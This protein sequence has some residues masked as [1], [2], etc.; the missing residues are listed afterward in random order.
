[1]DRKK[2]ADMLKSRVLIVDGA[3][4]TMLME[5]DVK[6]KCLDA[7]NIEQPE[8]VKSIHKAYADAGA[9]I[10][11]TNTFG[12]NRLKLAKYGYGNRVIAINQ[13]GVKNAREAAPGCIIA[14]DMGSLGKYIE[15]LSEMTFDEAYELFSEQA[16]GLKEADVI[17][18]ETISDIKVLKAA[19]LAARDNCKLPIIT[20]MTF[21]EGRTP[22]GTDVE[23][24]AAI[25][26]ALDVDAIGANCS[27]GPEGLLKVAEILAKNTGKPICIQPNAG[28]PRIADGKI[29][30]TQTA[31]NFSSYANQF[32]KLGVNLLGGCCGTT[33]AHIRAIAEKLKGKKPAARKIEEKTKLCSRLKTIA[34]E[35]KT[36][37]AGE[38]IN[39]TGKKTFQDELRAGKT[40]YIREQALEQVSQG[41]ALLDVN[42]GVAGLDEKKALP[43][44][45]EII[46]S[47]VDAPLV[48]DSSD[49]VALELA[50]KK[51][52]GKPLINSV[53]G[54]EKSLSSVLPLAKRYGAAVI[55]LTLDDE[56]IPK[57]AEKRV[58]IAEK[59]AGRAEKVGIKKQDIIVDCLVMTIATNPENEKIIIDSL[60]KIKE[61]GYKTILGISNISHGL[62]NRQEINSKFLT[63]SSR[64]GLD[65]AII[66][67]KDNIVQEN[68]DIE[69]F[70]AKKV[71]REEYTNLP[72]EKKL[73][74]AIFYGDKENIIDFIEE[75]LKEMDALR[76]NNILIEAL[77][78]LGDKFN[79]RECFLPQVLASAEAMKKAFSRLKQ[80]LSR[81]GGME[82]GTVLFATVENDVH[83]IGKNIVIALLES[84]NYK[85][86]DLGIDVPK[87][88]IIEAVK[89]YKPDMLG[90]SALMT[91]TAV[92]MEEI[93]KDLRKINIHIP[94]I[95][96]GAVVTKEYSE[97]IKA[98]YSKDALSA[99]KEINKLIQNGNVK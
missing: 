52:D 66:N 31:K 26:E 27:D 67:P 53:N 23:T 17:I 97:Q 98:N 72:I 43:R 90:L 47:L 2:F 21:H 84:H 45:V 89:K 51:S 99:V 83:D 54:S 35:N 14:G 7:L 78:E 44:A 37:I 94:I 34:I 63:K 71:R 76:I 93:I 70:R 87:E 64:A 77:N 22:T 59:I 13:A 3:M 74:N 28:L 38:R 69:V 88:K 40:N 9:D 80:E 61:M 65:L 30:Y 57:T 29:I 55:A 48:I 16:K 10:I 5:Q 86:I 12:A 42:V 58:E 41:A 19:V 85:V 73:F 11:I 36:L 18:I 62:P 15:P 81:E 1:M 33:P 68:T 79:K 24:Y 92:K 20:S 50:L 82:K 95:I 60:K 49:A 56:G 75:G 6:F 91:T 39:P 25:A 32:H 8:A 4:G 46:Q 96:G